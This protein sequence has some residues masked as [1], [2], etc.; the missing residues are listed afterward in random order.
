MELANT[1]TGAY[2][3]AIK[4]NLNSSVQLMVFVLPSD[5][6][7]LYDA[8]KKQCCVETPV[9]TQCVTIAKMR[10]QQMAI[11]TKIAVQINCKLGGEPWAVE[12]PVSS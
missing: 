10:K 8:I 9:P 3:D 4:A 5:K 1:S 6:K 7:D 2:I 12:I 11:V